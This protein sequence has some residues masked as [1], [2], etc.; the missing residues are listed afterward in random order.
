MSIGTRP[1]AQRISAKRPAAHRPSFDCPS[2][3]PSDF[4][5]SPDSAYLGKAGIRSPGDGMTDASRQ[6]KLEKPRKSSWWWPT[7][8][9]ASS[10]AGAAAVVAFRGCWHGKMSWPVGVQGCSYQVCLRCGAM[11]LFDEKTF[12]AYGPFRN[13]LNQLIAWEKSAKPRIPS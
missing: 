1:V 11:R 10:L 8:V 9:V 5:L 12:S 2:Y 13:D 3:D 6:H 7:G 4:A